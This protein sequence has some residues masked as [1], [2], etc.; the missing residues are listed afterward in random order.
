M[1]VRPSVAP[2]LAL[3]ALLTLLAPARA[4]DDLPDGR[5]LLERT[6]A[7]YAAHPRLGFTMRQVLDVPAYP[8]AHEDGRYAA[9]VEREPR[10]L[11]LRHLEGS[12]QLSMIVADGRLLALGKG[13]HAIGPAPDDL[14]DL[15]HD[16]RLG[17]PW[18]ALALLADLARGR[19]VDVDAPV[20]S[21]VREDLGGRPAFHLRLG[22]Q[23][24]VDLWIDAGDAP[25][26]LRWSPAPPDAS[27]L[28]E[29]VDLG[30]VM[31]IDVRFSDWTAEPALDGAFSLEPPADSREVSS[32]GRA[33]VEALPLGATGAP[34][35]EGD[36]ATKAPLAPD[37]TL[38]A[39]DGSTRKLSD[40]RG[41]VVVLDFWATWCKPCIQGLPILERVVD[42]LGPRGVVLWAVDVR[43]PAETIE[44]FFEKRGTRWPV[45]L[46]RDGSIAAAYGVRPIPHTVIVGK[47]GRVFDVHTGFD[48]GLEKSL[49]AKLRAALAE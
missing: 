45:A 36:A 1:R 19:M 13:R 41:Q 17:Q 18:P 24:Q 44:A 4:A 14:S 5:A 9:L 33:D 8:Q 7:H 11:A 16:D 12:P 38:T 48:D 43:E 15:P 32:L 31:R 3:F 2:T 30:H 27:E 47:D 6:A 49:R 46:D 42:E 28:P 29:G 34:A 26:V 10:R 20:A 22:A 40:L 37:V 21:L 25:W 23:R 39:L 35:D